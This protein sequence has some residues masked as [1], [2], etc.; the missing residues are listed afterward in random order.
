MICSYTE[1]TCEKY[2]ENK[3]GKQRTHKNVTK[4]DQSEGQN[5]EYYFMN[6]QSQ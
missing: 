2:P 5:M 1:D 6:N 3:G 4:D